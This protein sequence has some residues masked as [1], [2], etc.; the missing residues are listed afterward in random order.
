MREALSFLLSVAPAGYLWWVGQ[1][2]VRRIDDPAFPELRFA[3][4]QRLGIVIAVCL[5]SSLALSIDYAVL[6]LTLAVLGLLVANYPARREIFGE[7]WGL[8]G[9]L[10]FTLRFWLAM[11]GVWLLIAW[12]PMVIR[13]AGDYAVVVAVSLVATAV[14]WGHF[15]SRTFAWIAGAEPLV[16]PDL[17]TRFEE[18]LTRATCRKPRTLRLDT[19]GGFMVN[20]FALP[21]IERPAVLFSSDLLEALAPDETAAIFAHEI[22]HLEYFDRRRLLMRNLVVWLL[23]AAL[24]AATV[25]LDSGSSLFVTLGWVWPLAILLLLAALMAGSQRREHES[26]VRAVELTGDPDA[27]VRGLTKIHEL[28]RM[29]RRWREKSEGCLSHPSLARRIRAIREAAGAGEADPEAEAPPQVVVVRGAD[30]PSVVVVLAADRLHWLQGLDEEVGLEPRA[31]LQAAHDCRSI[32]YGELADLRLE[33]RGMGGRCLKAVDSRGATLRLAIRHEDVG[34]VKSVLETIDLK[35][36]LTAPEAAEKDAAERA[37]RRNSRTLASLAA[38][39]GLLPPVSMPLIVAAVLVFFRPVRATLTAAG[40]I[41]VAAGLAGLRSTG[42]GLPGGGSVSV[43][44]LEVALGGLLLYAALARHRNALPEPRAS[45]RL[46]GAVL[47]GLGLLY[48]AGGVGLLGVPLPVTQFHLWA[49]YQPGLTVVLLGLAGMSLSFRGRAAYWLAG[50]A[51]GVAALLVVVG[52]LW[53]RG[54]FA[55]DPLAPGRHP[56]Q[57]GTAR[58]QLIREIPL[59]GRSYGLRLAPSGARVAALVVDGK[60]SGFQVELADGGF[61][62]IEAVDLAFLDD[63]RIAVLVY[64]PTGSLSLQVLRLGSSPGTEYEIEIEPVTDPALR[65]DPL[66]GRWEVSGADLYEGRVKLLSGE[67]GSDTYRRSDWHFVAPDDSYITTLGAN[68]GESA[69]AVTTG[70]EYGSVAG[71]LMSLNPMVQ[72]S[73]PAAIWAVGQADQARLVTTASHFWCA[74]LLAGQRD[75]TCVSSY[76]RS[77]TAA[78]WSVDVLSEQ[79][80]NVVSIPG[81]Y[82]AATPAPGRTLLLNG[83]YSQPVL[84]DLSSGDAWRLDMPAPLV[85]Q[86]E[87]ESAETDESDWLLDLL[88]GESEPGVDYEAMA[89]QGE[90]VALALAR[91]DN[92][93]IRIYRINK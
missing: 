32:R 16:D 29:P 69:L 4:G 74:E 59:K 15:N 22:S 47:G 13:W 81:E 91:E 60:R 83:Y 61:V 71:L 27:L 65:V 40:A 72:Y 85:P 38:L 44:V 80:K 87:P 75:F 28:M 45:W 26:D 70:F 93:E 84:V 86:S 37:N 63:E 39:C 82:Y 19:R 21:A 51:A 55:S 14:V 92:T 25:W 50:A 36:R 6:K 57:L 89:I 30:E 3:R 10:C 41:G 64:Q 18:I 34:R 1:R 73:L 33:V 76:H 12:M 78:V 58:L 43:P 68:A 90:V 79:V 48:L 56:A 7:R 62:T 53:F 23:F 31:V 54:S 17:E 8:L 49:R 2:L 77:R 88:V 20:A 9:Y 11:L 52:T 42:A 67:I 24:L 35:V 46:P 66:G 5:I